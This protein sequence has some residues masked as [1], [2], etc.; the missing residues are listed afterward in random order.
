MKPIFE[1]TLGWKEDA[2]FEKAADNLRHTKIIMVDK[3]SIGVIKV[4]PKN[5]ELHFHQIQILPE[6]QKKGVA[7]KLIHQTI[8]CAEKSQKLLTL[9]VV[10]NTPAME[11]YNHLG[12]VIDDEFQYHCKMSK[13][14]GKKL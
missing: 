14:P 1:K 13:S 4:I 2:E 10:K 5:N 9:F 7:T 12:F 6:F 3:K 11:L 8:E